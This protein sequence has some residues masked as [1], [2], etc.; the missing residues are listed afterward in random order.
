MQDDEYGRQEKRAETIYEMWNN[1]NR[2]NGNMGI[3]RE[4]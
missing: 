3:Q 2:G 1:I 4:K